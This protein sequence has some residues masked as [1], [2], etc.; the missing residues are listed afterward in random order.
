MEKE[1]AG[2]IY[3][4]SSML[5]TPCYVNVM[6]KDEEKDT[7][8]ESSFD[9]TLEEVK[10]E[11]CQG[12]NG[13]LA[14]IIDALDLNL[15]DKNN[16]QSMSHDEDKR[17]F[18][19]ILVEKYYCYKILCEEMLNTNEVKDDEI[20]KLKTQAS[21]NQ[22]NFLHEKLKKLNSK[23]ARRDCVLRRKE[24]E[25]MKKERLISQRDK[26]ISEKNKEITTK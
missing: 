24:K 18:I 15:K 23:I 11:I 14:N 19:R 20:H 17:D 5:T 16:I 13:E 25:L 12:D 9:M 22:D 10:S 1:Q 26:E 3:G 2:P 6:H 21:I 8:E 7:I 4:L